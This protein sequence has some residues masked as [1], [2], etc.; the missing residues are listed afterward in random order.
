[1]QGFQR[2]LTQFGGSLG[3]FEDL[4]I[5]IWKIFGRLWKFL[6]KSWWIVI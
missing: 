4:Q 1:M 5:E 2:S 6:P 3:K